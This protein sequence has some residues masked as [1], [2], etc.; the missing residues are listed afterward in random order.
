MDFSLP[1]L[2]KPSTLV[3][4]RK[5]RKD[6]LAGCFSLAGIKKAARK[7]QESS[8]LL[9]LKSYKLYTNSVSLS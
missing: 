1:K 7:Q 2:T 6:F 4:E 9:L 5:E 3:G 8:S